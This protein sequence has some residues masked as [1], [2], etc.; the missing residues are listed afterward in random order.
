MTELPLIFIGGLLG[1]SHC[2]GMCGPLA[3]ALGMPESRVTANLRRQLVFSVGRICTYGFA[4]ALAAFAGLWLSQWSWLAVDV[5]AALA[6]VGGVAL[7][8]LGLT[9]AGIL[10]R[11]GLDWLA[12]QSCSAAVWLKTLLTSPKLPSAF[13]AGVFTGFIPC[14][15]VYAFLAMAA[16]TGDVVRGWL[17]MVT[18]GAGTVPLLVITGCGGSVLSITSRARV[19]RV[20]AWCVVI[21]GVISI[22]RGAAFIDSSQS[23]GSNGCPFCR[24]TE[25]TTRQQ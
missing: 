21:T 14:G 2:I 13:L 8:L 23:S 25:P 5:Q 1:S 4:G 10:P 19:L 11:M 15:L 16:G 18:F 6:I 3:L 9:T 24:Q 22:A 7:V 12:P 20:A 17:V